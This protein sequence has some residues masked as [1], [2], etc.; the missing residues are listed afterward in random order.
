MGKSI[1]KSLI[2]KQQGLECIYYNRRIHVLV[3]FTL[4][5]LMTLDVNTNLCT[6]KCRKAQLV[7]K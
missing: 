1:V 5:N 4:R 6:S 7:E 2:C 3:L